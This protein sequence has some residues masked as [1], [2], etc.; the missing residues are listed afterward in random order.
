MPKTMQQRARRWAL[1]TFNVNLPCKQ[2]GHRLVIPVR[3]GL[4][5]WYETE[6]YLLPVIR[7]LLDERTGTFMDVGASLGQ[8]LLKVK[9]S[10]PSASY[11]GIEPLPAC[12]SYL[13]ELISVNA[14]QHCAVICC[15]V[16]ST[17]GISK[18]FTMGVISE[19]SSL[20]PQS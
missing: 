18:L 2:F 12:A 6:T 15:A 4:H 20:A 1:E 8:T 5:S 14:F 19:V 10:F 16:G 9:L 11:I 3:G 17:C 13:N 7:S